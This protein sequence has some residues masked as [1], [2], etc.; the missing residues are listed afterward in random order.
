MHIKPVFTLLQVINQIDSG[1][2]WNTAQL[3]YGFA[4][5]I[6]AGGFPSQESDGISQFSTSQRE[7]T[8]IAIV[9]WADLININFVE[10]SD[11][12]ADILLVNYTGA[13]QAYAYLPPL[14]DIFVNPNQA[15]NLQ[16]NPGEFGLHTLVHEL[17]H[18]LGL[19][20]LGNYDSERGVL[21]G[22]RDQAE[23]EQDSRQYSVMSYWSASNTGANHGPNNYAA[24]PLLHDIAT[25]Q[26]IY[27]ANLSTRT[28][29]T[30]YGFNSTANRGVFDF[31][32]SFYTTKT[33]IIAIW[34]A[35]GTDTLD[36]S[37][38]S[39]NARIDLNDGA[40]S[41]AGGL[42]LNIS[43]A[44]NAFIENAVGGSGNDRITGQELANRLNG[45]R[46]NDVLTGAAGNDV[47]IGGIGTD[48]AIYSGV[49][50]DYSIT[51][52]GGDQYT[53]TGPDGTDTLSGI[54]R[55][56]FD[57]GTVYTIDEAIRATEL[58]TDPTT[59]PIAPPGDAGDTFATAKLIT[60]NT[61]LDLD[62]TVGFDQDEEDYFVFTATTTGSL[63]ATLSGLSADL[64]LYLYNSEFIILESSIAASNSSEAITYNVQQGSTY[65]LLVH[66]YRDAQSAY[67]ASLSISS[68]VID[69]S[70]TLLDATLLTLPATAS[71]SVGFASDDDDYFQIRPDSSGELHLTL[72]DLSSDIDLFVYDSVFTIIA[73]S[74]LA[75]SSSEE[76]FLN[77]LAGDTYYI[78]VDPFG[79]AQSNYTLKMELQS[80]GTST[81]TDGNDTIQTAAS[82]SLPG[83]VSQTIGFNDDNNDFFS[84][85]ATQ[86]GTVTVELQGLSSD[87]DLNMLSS[88]GSVLTS[89]TNSGSTSEALAFYVTNGI[90]YYIEVFPYL[91]FESTY[92]L[93]THFTADSSAVDAGNSFSTASSLTLGEAH[94]QDVGGNN[95]SEDFFRVV[96]TSEGTLNVNISSLSADI[97]MYLFDSNQ[98]QI[99]ASTLAGTSNETI[100]QAVTEGDVFFLNISPYQTAESS[101]TLLGNIT[102]PIVLPDDPELTITVNDVNEVSG[103][104]SFDSETSVQ[105][106]YISYFGRPAD[107]AGLAFYAES[108]SVGA[109]TINAIASSFSDSTEAQAVIA[110][111]T[112]TYLSA[113]Y[114]QAF[115]RAY[116]NSADADGT[117]WFD[118]IERGTTT[119]E[120]AMVQILSGAQGAD[121]T[122]VANK[123]AVSNAFTN[124]VTTE[125]KTYAGAVNAAAA[126][127]VLD[128]VT[129]DAVTVTSGNMAAQAAV[130][131]LTSF[132]LASVVDTFVGTANDSTIDATA[133]VEVLAGRSGADSFV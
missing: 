13:G 54:E 101:Y 18:S 64:D 1:T 3:N 89:S 96:A 44:F 104:V 91:D 41:D 93:T 88:S 12:T 58:V 113:V 46:G 94:I 72:T 2:R 105:E 97:D 22:Y 9:L 102:N 84:F 123:V 78:G 77:V 27:G 112:D 86:N 21:L 81:V 131:L 57:I 24:T 90:T 70:D 47:L 32:S 100:S 25:I 92:E 15:G 129:S 76:I 6:P 16:L 117:F 73:I 5:R 120:L 52:Q 29:N 124:A 132:S 31:S 99:A 23:Y 38:Y 26:S 111:D 61:S 33:P 50:T 53:I 49:V 125:G 106:L 45:G 4:T 80:D 108:L 17:G 130:T 74:N 62:G 28:G 75:G 95:D 118:A 66:P 40:F 114:L 133:K 68:T 103:T 43:I 59:D 19:K 30:V 60:L 20:H 122:A 126:K 79:I 116:D 121:I 39:S 71:Q 128:A 63:S 48:M 34:D 69:A 14:G 82:I 55:L 10:T 65:Y 110:L 36:L 109:T 11:T 83:T 98:N 37:G 67:T 115:A 119:K 35:G 7:A 42:T 8:R 87:I 127:A 51:S 107:P 56:Q 85:I